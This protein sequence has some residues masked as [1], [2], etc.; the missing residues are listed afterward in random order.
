[1]KE[2]IKAVIQVSI[3][4][5]LFLLVSYIVQ[6]NMGF[7]ENLILG[8]EAWGI[9]IYTLI[10]IVETIIAPLTSIPLIPIISAIYGWF[11][12]GIIAYLGW[13]LG[14]VIIF[15]ICR[16]WGKPFVKKF[17][18]LESIERMERSIS[19]EEEMGALILL[20]MTLPADIVSYALGLF[21]GISWKT[22]LISTLI[23]FL[24]FTFAIAYVGSLPFVYQILGAI[25]LAIVVITGIYFR[26]R[27]KRI[28]ET[29]NLS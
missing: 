1:M 22:Y 20:R 15:Y 21:S 6:T 26:K 12:A 4:V 18:S 5:F 7:F 17:V 28:K 27:K 2:K 8:N 16:K 25:V 14:S 29:K 24:P 9:L 23:G 10:I 11:V 19:K 13:F 3:I